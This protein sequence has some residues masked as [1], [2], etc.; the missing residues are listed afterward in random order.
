MGGSSWRVLRVG[1]VARVV[2][3]TALDGHVIATSCRYRVGIPHW[4]SQQRKVVVPGRAPPRGGGRE[5][6]TSEGPCRCGLS[7]HAVPAVP[8]QPT[9]RV[10]LRMNAD[11]DVFRGSPCRRLPGRGGTSLYRLP[12]RT[13]RATHAA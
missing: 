4:A 10:R 12:L 8:R 1:S 11:A 9:R 2:A 6:K 3:P 7:A 5:E 13:V